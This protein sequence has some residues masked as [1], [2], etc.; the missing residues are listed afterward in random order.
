MINR[1]VQTTN[2]WDPLIRIFHWSLAFFFFLAYLTEDDWMTIHSYAGYSIALLISFRLIWGLIG[3]RHAR[4]SDFVTG[5]RQ[6]VEYIKQMIVGKSRRYIGH[7]PAGAAMTLILLS[8][9]A[10]TAFSGVSLFA[11]E[12][13]GPLAGTFVATW[14]E[15]V[16]EEIHEFFA[17]FTLLMVVVHVAGVLFSSLLHRENLTV[18]MINGEKRSESVDGSEDKDG[19]GLGEQV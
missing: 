2:V 15:D 10:L 16:L 11:T 1:G 9:L 17:N 4:F 5:P 13:H 7:N 12:E 8:S 6:V 18:A 14:S 3:T 19:A